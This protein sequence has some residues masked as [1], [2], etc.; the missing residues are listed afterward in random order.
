MQPQWHTHSFPRVIGSCTWS[1]PFSREAFWKFLFAIALPIFT[2]AYSIIAFA[3]LF[4]IVLKFNGQIMF[5]LSVVTRSTLYSY[6]IKIIVLSYH[7]LL[8]NMQHI[9]ERQSYFNRV[10][11]L[12]ILYIW[13]AAHA[14]LP[15]AGKLSLVSFAKYLLPLFNSL[16][17]Q[18]FFGVD[19]DHSQSMKIACWHHMI[20]GKLISPCWGN[21]ARA[22]SHWHVH[23]Y[24]VLCTTVVG[25]VTM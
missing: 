23:C 22:S 1:H 19:I 9:K 12:C 4:G 16:P 20:R 5:H 17:I 7:M 8:S 3:M 13:P 11:T 21:C 18:L 6:V 14:S 15:C 2:F 24:A 25:Y 10:W